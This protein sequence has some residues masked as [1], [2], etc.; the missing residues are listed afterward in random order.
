MRSLTQGRRQYFCC[1]QW[2]TLLAAPPPFA[3]MSVNFSFPYVSAIF[4][5]VFSPIL[6]ECTLNHIQINL[7]GK[8]DIRIELNFVGIS[9]TIIVQHLN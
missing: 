7:A 4:T 9:K 8:V 5:M 3:N 6:S 2:V 1:G